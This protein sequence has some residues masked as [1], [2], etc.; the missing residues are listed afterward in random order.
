MTDRLRLTWQQTF[1]MRVISFSTARW[2]FSLLNEQ[3]WRERFSE[4]L[5]VEFRIARVRK[6][7]VYVDG[8]ILEDRCR[9]LWVVEVVE[10]VGLITCEKVLYRHGAKQIILRVCKW[11]STQRF[12]PHGGWWPGWRRWR[13]QRR[14]G[15]TRKRGRGQSTERQRT[16]RHKMTCGWTCFY[17]TR[18]ATPWPMQVPGN[19]DEMC[20]NV[21]KNRSVKV[22]CSH[23]K[24]LHCN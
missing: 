24:H 22:F 5:I 18:A 16:V 14:C 6:F 4:K 12:R 17:E 15:V 23:R 1:F 21:R 11:F 13:N 2:F 8:F 20:A 9:S 10:L 3:W 19:K 7:R